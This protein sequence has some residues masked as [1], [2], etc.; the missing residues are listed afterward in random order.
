[1]GWVAAGFVTMFGADKGGDMGADLSTS[2]AGYDDID[3]PHTGEA[4]YVHVDGTL[5]PSRGQINGSFEAFF[6]KFCCTYPVYLVTG[7]DR[8]KT[9]DQLGLDMLQSKGL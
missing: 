4:L 3:I 9:V 2:Y 5:T 8:Q 7:G 1:M 6:K